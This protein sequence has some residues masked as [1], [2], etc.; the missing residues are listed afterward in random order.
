MRY[1]QDILLLT[2]F[3][4]WIL[5]E[6]KIIITHQIEGRRAVLFSI[7]LLLLLDM[8]VITKSFYCKVNISSIDL[9][10]TKY[11]KKNKHTLQ[12]ARKRICPYLGRYIADDTKFTFHDHTH[13]Q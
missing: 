13:M 12:H 11:K 7:T 5:M 9:V 3:D 10:V 6:N 1:V 2:K 4:K 8:R